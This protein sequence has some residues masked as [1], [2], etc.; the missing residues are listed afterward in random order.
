MLTLKETKKTAQIRAG[1]Y[2]LLSQC[3]F[4]PSE[5][6]VAS[7]NQENLPES[8]AN[9][10]GVL[11]GG[12]HKEKAEKELVK[13]KNFCSQ[14]EKKSPAETL[15]LLKVEYNRLF[16]GP[17]HVLAPPYESVY[18][19]RDKD[20]QLGIVMGE[21]TIAVRKLYRQAGLEIADSFKDLPDHIAV[22]LYFMSYLCNLEF[23]SADE[24]EESQAEILKIKELQKEFLIDHL[25]TWIADFSQAVDKE[26][27]S[28]FYRSIARISRE[29]IS[30]EIK[31]GV[32]Y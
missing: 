28:E 22:E 9:T 4:R 16:V 30:W 25:G 7:M 26:T 29:W 21:D 18:K 32:E 11:M 13:I 17:G 3:F 6:L 27:S 8:L 14:T 1:I 2:S 5:E 20:N 19:T 24:E 31:R 23:L 12:S 10:V 15:R